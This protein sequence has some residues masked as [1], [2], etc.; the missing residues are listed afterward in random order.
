MQLS[1]SDIE[2]IGR[3]YPGLIVSNDSRDHIS[4]SLAFIMYFD[5]SNK[6]YIINPSDQSKSNKFRI[7][8]EYQIE[9]NFRSINRYSLPTARETAGRIDNIARSK[10]MDLRDLHINSDGD[11]CLC[12]EFETAI[13]LP[14]GFNI[15]DYFYNLL[16]PFFYA[17][18]Y[19]EKYNEWPWGQ[20]SHG[21]LGLF[22]WYYEY[23]NSV[24]KQLIY[25][26]ISF[27]KRSNAWDKYKAIFQNKNDIKG[28]NCC[29]C[30][31][32]NKFRKCHPNVLSGLWKFKNDIKL[33]SIK[34]D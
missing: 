16:I 12:F 28:H 33:L 1:G 11:A 21:D 4:G 26:C 10:K 22:E 9:I 24:P 8:D 34:F 25:E 23:P 17:Q 27:L 18:S 14:N 7:Q 5:E 29:I 13:H 3:N 20:Y 31:S 19:F 32:M 6:Q 30:G 2:W 15:P